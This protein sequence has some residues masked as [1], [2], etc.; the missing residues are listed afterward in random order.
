[1]TA[2]SPTVANR[3]G[4]GSR[5][6]VVVPSGPSVPVS[7]VARAA[8]GVCDLVWL[9]RGD[10]PEAAT[11][12]R[13]LRRFGT[14]VDATD[15]DAEGTAAAVA[16]LRPSGALA[17]ADRDLVPLADLAARL[18]LPF[19][20]PTTARRLS[21]GPAPRHV[22][23]E[24]GVGAPEPTAVREL[25]DRLPVGQHPFADSVSVVSVADA[26]GLHHLAVAGRLTA[27][28]PL[29]E[30]GSFIPSTL[31][32]ADTQSVL[33]TAGDALGALGV[34]HGCCHTTV[35]M[36]QDGPR[37][38]E[39]NGR[40]GD[41]VADMLRVA[42]GLDLLGLCLRLALGEPAGIDGPVD[43]ARVGYRLF[44]RPP[45]SA[46]AP[47]SLKGVRAVTALPGV[48]QVLAHLDPDEAVEPGQRTPSFVLAVLG[49]APDHDG[50]LRANRLAQEAA[51][52]AHDHRPGTGASPVPGGGREPVAPPAGTHDGPGTGS[53]A[54]RGA[55]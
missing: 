10:D 12:R 52:I 20:S 39:V 13:V 42:A 43:C 8:A 54:S 47:R 5:P 32:P 18:G 2:R 14:V 9:V 24:A 11:A 15:L 17:L 31:G 33:A 22:Q 50:L 36:A 30:R 6:A 44:L 27:A 48:D 40:M 16:P 51:A 25:P 53:R 45:R 26:V 1:M 19:H 3:Q 34:R 35:T 37:V 29:R 55:A 28:Q 23:D 46:M 21:E 49:S 41:G 4:T 38:V 7:Q